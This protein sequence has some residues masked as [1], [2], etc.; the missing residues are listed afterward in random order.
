MG[1]TN[2]GIV[3]IIIVII[4][5]AVIITWDS[6]TKVEW[7]TTPSGVRDNSTEAED[8][9]RDHLPHS[10]LLTGHSRTFLVMVNCDKVLCSTTVKKVPLWICLAG[11]QGGKGRRGQTDEH[12]A[13]HCNK[14]RDHYW[15]ESDVV[16][17]PPYMMDVCI[18]WWQVDRLFHMICDEETHLSPSPVV[19]DT[20][21]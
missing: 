17:R 6:I 5:G 2:D 13:H 16:S 8:R 4:T 1:R 21:L 20:T 19:G 14:S 15:T 12:Q 10:P 18:L 7:E 3:N 9:A 11:M